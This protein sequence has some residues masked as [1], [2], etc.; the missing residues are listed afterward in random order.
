M[1]V[2]NGFVSNSSTSSFLCI[3]TVD[4]YNDA[5]SKLS[6]EDQ[7]W[8]SMWAED[9]SIGDMPFKMCRSITGE[10]GDVFSGK[11]LSEF[12]EDTAQWFFDA[13]DEFS[14]ALRKQG[15]AFIEYDYY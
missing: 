3:T 1:K 15:K 9:I 10:G 5:L 7:K 12:N 11:I 4:D 14:C 6:E 8:I 13:K 2:R